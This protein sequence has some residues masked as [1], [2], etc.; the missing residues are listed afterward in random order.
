MLSVSS[1]FYVLALRPYQ[2]DLDLVPGQARDSETAGGVVTS[3]GPR[4]VQTLFCPVEDKA[5]VKKLPSD[6]IAPC[7]QAHFWYDYV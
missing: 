7:L 1:I 6:I 2:S 5:D 3:F 4:T